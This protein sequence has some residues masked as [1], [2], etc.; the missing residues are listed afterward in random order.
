M[1]FVSEFAGC[2]PLLAGE[3]VATSDLAQSTVSEHLRILRNAG[4]GFARQDGPRSWYCLRRSVLGEFA[5][6]VGEMAAARSGRGPHPA[7]TKVPV[8]HRR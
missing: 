4:V 5:A 1:Q 7:G 8:A 3:L 6:A 2:L